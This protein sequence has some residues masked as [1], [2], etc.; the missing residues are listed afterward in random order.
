MRCASISGRRCSTRSGCRVSVKQSA[1]RRSRPILRS[2]S[3]NS[4]APPSVLSWSP[5][6]SATT[7]REKCPSNNN[8][9]WLHSVI[10]KAVLPLASTT[11]EHRS[12]AR[13]NGLFLVLITTIC[14]I[15]VRNSGY[16][17]GF[18]GSLL[19]AAIL[20]EQEKMTYS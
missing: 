4:S 12:Y 20:C 18:H 15:L 16:T 1:T 19:F 14:S 7:R 13:E 17:H 6:N 8:C 3:R 11:S 10:I 9:D 5:E 2:A